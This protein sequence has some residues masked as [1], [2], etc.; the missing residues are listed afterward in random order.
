MFRLPTKQKPWTLSFSANLEYDDNVALVPDSTQ[1]LHPIYHI[2][3]M[4]HSIQPG[5][6]VRIL[7]Q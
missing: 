4:A 1:I 7:Q 6:H 2:G 5:R 3:G